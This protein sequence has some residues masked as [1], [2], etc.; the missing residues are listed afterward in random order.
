MQRLDSVNIEN[1]TK[2]NNYNW[3]IHGYFLNLRNIE[4]LGRCVPQE[5]YVTLHSCIN[6]HIKA[7]TKNSNY[8]YLEIVTQCRITH[9]FLLKILKSIK[10]ISIGARLGISRH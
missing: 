2:A 1:R 3:D 4:F 7:V 8:E 10:S 9:C 5:V 6:S